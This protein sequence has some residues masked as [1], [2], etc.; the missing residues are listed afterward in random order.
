MER[1]EA[2]QQEAQSDSQLWVEIHNELENANQRIYDQLFGGASLEILNENFSITES[3]NLA[4]IK[5]YKLFEKPLGY[6][7]MN[8]KNR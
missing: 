5:I 6:F 8:I 4:T 7:L 1:D 2:S 3:I